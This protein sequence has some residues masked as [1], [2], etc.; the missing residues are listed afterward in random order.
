MDYFVKFNPAGQVVGVNLDD[1]PGG[2]PGTPVNRQ[3]DGPTNATIIGIYTTSI[4][5]TQNPSCWI[6]GPGGWYKVPC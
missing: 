2:G 4:I 3:A 1:H 6:P 5:K